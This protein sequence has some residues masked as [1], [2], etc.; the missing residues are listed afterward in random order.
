MKR[1]ESFVSPGLV[2]IQQGEQE[3]LAT[4]YLRILIP[5]TSHERR[6][7]V[8]TLETII[9]DIQDSQAQLL[10]LTLKLKLEAEERVLSEAETSRLS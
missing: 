10:M 1:T 7:D 4:P 2:P 8:D 3:E 6:L 9:P 5:N